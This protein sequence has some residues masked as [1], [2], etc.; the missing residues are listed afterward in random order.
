[1]ATSAP[2]TLR[3]LPPHWL[4]FR[5]RPPFSPPHSPQPHHGPRWIPLFKNCLLASRAANLPA[6]HRRALLLHCLGP[7][8]QHISDAPPPPPTAPQLLTAKNLTTDASSIR[9]SKDRGEV[10]KQDATA[11]SLP[12]VYNASCKMPA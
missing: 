11:T 4:R 6:P 1:M 3:W 12:D 8:G 10:S 7:K 5:R 9:A 2:I